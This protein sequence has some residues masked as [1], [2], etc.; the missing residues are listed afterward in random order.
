MKPDL[1]PVDL[2]DVQSSLRDWWKT[3][4]G[5]SYARAWNSVT[6]DTVIR[7][8]HLGDVQADALGKAETFWVSQE[9]VSVI[10]VAGETMPPQ[11]LRPDDAPAP[12]G[13]VWFD[14]PIRIIDKGGKRVGIRAVVWSER[15]ISLRY[16]DD[17]PPE[18]T[19]PLYEVFTRDED[20]YVRGLSM[21]WYSDF[22]DDEDET[23]HS[24]RADIEAAGHA[25]ETWKRLSHRLQMFH[26]DVWP[27]GI[28]FADAEVE[29]HMGSIDTRRFLVA[30]F[31]LQGQRLARTE[32]LPTPR[33]VRRRLERS[34]TLDPT[35]EVRT[36]TLRRY[37]EPGVE[38]RG[39]DR[40]GP[41]EWSHQWIV[42]GHWRNQWVPSIEDHRLTWIA[43]YVKGPEDRPLLVRDTVFKVS[44]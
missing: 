41:I 36:I 6:A 22:E 3:D 34:G 44:R 12:F 14:R 30:F 5:Q 4:L 7:D 28:S 13:F 17:S 42:S 31:A 43:P 33:H 19:D 23:N 18:P 38:D 37:R 27:Y 11:P 10:Q 32:R 8:E 15:S 39:E 1:R 16:R 2:L 20:G 40:G 21:A 9:M 29:E 25:W 24:I 35:K 26:L